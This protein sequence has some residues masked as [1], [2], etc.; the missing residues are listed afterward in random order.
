[1]VRRPSADEEEKLG[2][3]MARVAPLE[4]PRR[5]DL[6][7]VEGGAGSEAVRLVERIHELGGQPG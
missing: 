1:M 2:L 5:E 7:R 3:G 4:E 6:H